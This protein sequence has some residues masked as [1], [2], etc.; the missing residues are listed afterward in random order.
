[1]TLQEA[2]NATE[3]ASAAFANS[4]QTT[5]NDGQAAD[6]IKAKLVIA[7]ETVNADQQAQAAAAQ[8]FNDSLDALIATAT[9]SKITVTA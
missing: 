1:M 8:A 6:T 7:M 9:A 4:V 5:N 2:I 3:Q